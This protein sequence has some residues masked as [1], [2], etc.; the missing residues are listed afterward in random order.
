[1]IMRNGKPIRATELPK[2]TRDD[3][4]HISD[5]ALELA[6]CHTLAIGDFR[7]FLVNHPAKDAIRERLT[8]GGISLNEAR[9]T[10]SP[11]QANHMTMM[12]KAMEICKRENSSVREYREAMTCVRRMHGSDV[13]DM[14]LSSRFF[15]ELVP[16]ELRIGMIS[17]VMDI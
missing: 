13:V 3:L 8:N 7:H 16:E 11:I 14:A 5:V 2:Y 12:H 9:N 4:K 10:P 6:C 15:E 17:Q 1:M